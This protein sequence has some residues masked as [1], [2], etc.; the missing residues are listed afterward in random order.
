[1]GSAWPGGL[2]EGAEAGLGEE[3]AGVF[4]EQIERVRKA[5]ATLRVLGADEKP[6]AGARVSIEQTGHE[7]LFGC[8]IPTRNG[9]RCEA[10]APWSA[11]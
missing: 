10:P 11:R 8:A 6:L 5:D 4:S 7:F 9:I 1:M 2:G 3:S